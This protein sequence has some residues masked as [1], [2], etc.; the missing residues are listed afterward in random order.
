MAPQQTLCV[1]DDP[2]DNRILECAVEAQSDFIVS[3]DSDLLRLRSYSGIATSFNAASP[4]RRKGCLHLFGN[5]PACLRGA[6]W[7]GLGNS[8]EIKVRSEP[9][10]RVNDF[11]TLLLSI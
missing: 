9:P 3:N 2:D 4:T 10:V 6:L 8:C 1:T 11:E 7:A 5:A